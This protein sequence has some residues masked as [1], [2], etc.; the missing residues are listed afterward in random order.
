VDATPLFVA[1]AGLY[2][3]HTSD[4]ETIAA[5]WPN[6]RAAL[7]WIGVYG[8][9]DGDG[10]VEYG[11][12]RE[13]G[14]ANQGWKDSGDAVFHADGRLAAGPV[15]L[16]EVQGYV[17]LA[18]SLGAQVAAAMGEPELA[19]DLTQKAGRLR[20]LFEQRFWSD[21]MGFY[22]LA[23]DAE[24]RQCAVRASNAGQVL[25]SG[26]AGPARAAHVARALAAP[27]L[28]SG[29]GVRTLAAGAA[30]FNPASYHNG[31]IWP[32]DNAMIVLGLARYGHRDQVVR[33]TSALLAAAAQMEGRRLPELFCGFHRNRRRGP[34]PYPV[35]CSPQAWAAATPFALLAACLGLEIDG[36][37]ATVH[38]KSP[39]LLPA[40]DWLRI[41]GLRAGAGRLDVLLRRHG[42]GVAAEVLAADG[43]ARLLVTA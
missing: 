37:A 6:I 17:Y 19:A 18:W 36:A 33:I 28:F 25:F 22:A 42:A 7:E 27:A 31:S 1:L 30:R 41:S 35:A 5:L 11:R 38:F 43:P 32:H 40:L 9:R 34:T 39:R 20:A 3:R 14:L 29:W 16:V 10:F 26:I 24:K 21:E 15:A 13:T 23:L 12:Q 4:R 2:L 8:D